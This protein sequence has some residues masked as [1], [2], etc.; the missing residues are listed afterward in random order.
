MPGPGSVTTKANDK[1]R[2]PV[3]LL[4][5]DEALLRLTVAEALHDRGFAVKEACHG[6]E[7][8]EI[9]REKGADID[10]LFT[11]IRLPGPINGWHVAF[12]FRFIHPLRPVIYATG[13]SQ[14]LPPP[15]AGSLFL[16]KPY[17]L[18]QILE[19]LQT[20]SARS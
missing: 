7:A 3:V 10:L 6:E 8:L 17:D 12:A 1:A 13:W 2:R 14:D 5:E 18:E 11:D 20:L 15:V 19:A 16:R 9:L 4:V